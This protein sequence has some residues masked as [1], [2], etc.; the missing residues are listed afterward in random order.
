VNVIATFEMLYQSQ[1]NWDVNKYNSLYFVLNKAIYNEQEYLRLLNPKLMT[2]TTKAIIKAHINHYQ[3]FEIYEKFPNLAEI[4]NQR[5]L[6]S[7]IVL[8]KEIRL[9]TASFREMNLID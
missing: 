8:A 4:A 3:K 2:N 7:E 9:N 6:D 5:P 1:F